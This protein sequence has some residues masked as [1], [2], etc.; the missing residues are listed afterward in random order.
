[1]RSWAFAV[2][3]DGLGLTDARSWALTPLEFEALVEV[4]EF[5]I[6]RENIYA[7]RDPDD[8]LSSPAAVTRRAQ[9]AADR[10]GLEMAQRMDARL[11]QKMFT[12][13]TLTEIEQVEAM[14]P[15]WARMT[16]DEKRQRRLIQ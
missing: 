1:M 11:G 8:F 14:I 15:K 7:G 5:R 10:K 6:Q 16:D 4:H 3:P 12:A 9:R 13:K 2:S